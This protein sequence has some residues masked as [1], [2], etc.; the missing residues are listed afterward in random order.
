MLRDEYQPAISG[1]GFG[2]RQDSAPAYQ[3]IPASVPSSQGKE[4]G[5]PRTVKP[6]DIAAVA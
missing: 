1:I 5:K 4:S 6:R 2:D 3:L